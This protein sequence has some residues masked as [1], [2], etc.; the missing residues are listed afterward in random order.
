MYRAFAEEQK[1]GI[2]TCFYG[3]ESF[4]F[5]ALNRLSHNRLRART[6]RKK[7]GESGLLRLYDLIECEAWSELS[8]AV[9]KNEIG[10]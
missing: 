10:N 7:Y 1:Y 9:L 4:V 3:K 8:A 2:L 6:I 5:R